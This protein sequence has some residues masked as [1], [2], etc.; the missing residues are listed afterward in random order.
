MGS[1][2]ELLGQPYTTMIHQW[3]S[4][5]SIIYILKGVNERAY[6]CSHKTG[7]VASLLRGQPVHKM[8]GR[9]DATVEVVEIE[10]L[11]GRVHMVV[12]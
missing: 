1:G 8:N 4:D 9:V 12:G 2:P 3:A 11:V 7:Q 6:L 5:Y 10:L